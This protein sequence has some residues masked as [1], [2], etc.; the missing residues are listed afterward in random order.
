M[1]IK[2]TNIIIVSLITLTVGFSAISKASAKT[3]AERHFYFMKN[4]CGKFEGELATQCLQYSLARYKHCICTAQHQGDTQS[5]LREC[6]FTPDPADY[7]FYVIEIAEPLEPTTT[8][9]PKSQIDSGGTSGGG[10]VYEEP[11]LN[12][13]YNP[14]PIINNGGTSG[15]GSVYVEPKTSSSYPS[16]IIKDRAGTVKR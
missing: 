1:R 14:S 15:G 9:K 10:S 4:S 12:S 6:G 2:T 5:L 16:P 7:G 13:S 8:Y 11:S 3:C